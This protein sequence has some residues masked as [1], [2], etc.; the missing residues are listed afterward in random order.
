[1]KKII[2]LLLTVVYMHAENDN[3]VTAEYGVTWI[4][5]YGAIYYDNKLSEHW[6][7][8]SGLNVKPEEWAGTDDLNNTYDGWYGMELGFSYKLGS[9]LPDEKIHVFV[10]A[11]LLIGVYSNQEK[12]LI[13]FPWLTASAYYEVDETF[14]IGV[15]TFLLQ[16][17]SLSLQ[18][19]F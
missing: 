8:R 1:M 5:S 13:G 4:G 17:I 12:D 19:N 15:S 9:I 10:N 2:V 11:T 3:R 7:F 16:S 6:S 18:H 14:Y